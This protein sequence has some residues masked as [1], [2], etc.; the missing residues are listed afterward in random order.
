MELIIKPGGLIEGKKWEDRQYKPVDVTESALYHLMSPC[1]L[2]EG[3]TLRDIFLIL[4]RDIEIYQVIINN[5]VEEIVA[6]GLS[7]KQRP[8]E[9]GDC[10][11]DYLELYWNLE[12]ES[13]KHSDFGGYIFP[14][15]HGWGSWPEDTHT[16][17]GTK[18][19]IGVDF[20]P[21]YEL[22]DLPLRLKDTAE[23][24]FLE[25]Y[26]YKDAERREVAGPVYSLFHI[27]YGIVWELSFMGSPDSR[28]NKRVELEETVRR[29]D[30][31]EEKLIPLEEVM[32]ELGKRVESAEED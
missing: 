14:C 27:L 28:D 24:T 25:N 18:G 10:T 12:A 20:S 9:K 2:E 23:V 3:V 22:I 21:S 26:K 6:E 19:G 4:Q 1:T 30:S 15:F 29:I 31:G 32:S 17:A 13:G 5:W 7:G 8:E 11:I 16:P